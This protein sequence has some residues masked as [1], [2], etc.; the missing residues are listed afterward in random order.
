[1][2]SR[3]ST[4]LIASTAVALVIAGGSYGIVSAISSSGSGSATAASSAVVAGNVVPLRRGSPAPSKVVGPV[5]STWNPGAGTLVT[6]SAASKATAAALA[7]Y[8][9][10]KVD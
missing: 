6:G 5:P 4:R 2:L 7:A 8:H 3:K 9:G 1:M 10:G